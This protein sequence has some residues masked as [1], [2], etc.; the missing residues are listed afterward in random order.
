MSIKID[1]IVVAGKGIQGPPGQQGPAGR[2]GT[3]GAPGA[4]GDIGPQ[5]PAGQGVPTGGTA[6]Q[7]LVKKSGINYDTEWK[8]VNNVTSTQVEKIV[9]MTQAEYDALTTKEAT[10]LYLIK[11]E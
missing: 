5:G 1:G 2:D 11:E 9:A 7:I 6:G 3:D 10:T 8:T 4:K